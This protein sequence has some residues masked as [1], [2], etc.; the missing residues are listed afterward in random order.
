ML[1]WSDLAIS[2]CPFSALT[3]YDENKRN[4]DVKIYYTAL[5][6]ASTSLL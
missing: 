4:D 3:Y 6:G 5:H 2:Y 1:M